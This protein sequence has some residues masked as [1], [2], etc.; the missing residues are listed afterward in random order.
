VASKHDALSSNSNA[1]KS[2]EKKENKFTENISLHS[3]KAD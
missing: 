1:I 2:K 3:E